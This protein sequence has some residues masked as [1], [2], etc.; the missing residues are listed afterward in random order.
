[1]YNIKQYKKKLIN[2]ITNFNKISVYH[3]ILRKIFTNTILH[4]SKY[5]KFIPYEI[6]YINGENGKNGKSETIIDKNQTIRNTGTVHDIL[7]YIPEDNK[8]KFLSFD[9]IKQ[10]FEYYFSKFKDSAE[11]SSFNTDSLQEYSFLIPV[12][13]FYLNKTS[14][15]YSIKF[16]DI[17]NTI[18]KIFVKNLNK[19]E[20]KFSF[21]EIVLCFISYFQQI[22]KEGEIIDLLANIQKYYE[23]PFNQISTDDVFQLNWDSK[24]LKAVFPF[25]SNKYSEYVN[26]NWLK[27]IDKYLKYWLKYEELF[28]YNNIKKIETNYLVVT[29]EGLSSILST[30]SRDNNKTIYPLYKLLFICYNE[31]VSNRILKLYD[32]SGKEQLDACLHFIKQN[33]V[34]RHRI[35]ISCHF[36][37][38]V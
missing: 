34:H 35:D 21:S 29:I 37:N 31:C 24:V 28:N 27:I 22:N 20:R 17:V 3:N 8:N 14:S 9:G 2:V 15:K 18:Y 10:T 38:S 19:I 23:E 26:E 7:T 13:L 4:Q 11:S 16:K 30:L 12:I 25:T 1:M 6:I 5:N 36:Y 32:K 33:S